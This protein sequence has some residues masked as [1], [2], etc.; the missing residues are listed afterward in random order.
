MNRPDTL[1]PLFAP[2]ANLK[3]VG[4]QR[5]K[6]LEKLC[7]G[8]KILNL[9]AHSPKT[10][11][12]RLKLK[13]IVELAEQKNLHEINTND[14]DVINTDIIENKEAQIPAIAIVLTILEH[15]PPARHRLPYRIVCFDESNEKIELLWF[16]LYSQNL[17]QQFPPTK[18]ITVCGSITYYQGKPQITHPERL[19]PESEF[20][21]LNTS[22]PQWRLTQGITRPLLIKALDEAIKAVPSLPEWLPYQL[23]EKY[24]YPNFRTAVKNLHKGTEL[25]SKRARE[26]LAY[27]ELLAHQISLNMVKRNWNKHKNINNNCLQNSE[28]KTESILNQFH[29]QLLFEPTQAQ[30]Q[31]VDDIKKDLKGEYPM[32]RLLQGDVGSGKTYVAACAMLQAISNDGQAVLMVPTDLLARQHEKSFN[33]WLEPL[34]VKVTLLS[35]SINKNSKLEAI[36]DIAEGTA[37]IIIGTHALFQQD[38][39]YKKLKLAVIDEQHKFGVYQRV[40]LTEKNKS[41]NLLV[42]SATPIPRTLMLAVWGGIDCSRLKQKPAGRKHIITKAISTKRIDEVILAL[43]KWRAQGDKIYWVCPHIKD[44]EVENITS[45]DNITSVQQR[46]KSLAEKFSHK[47]VASMHAQMSIQAREKAMQQFSE[48]EAD[49]LVATTMI[50]VGIDIPEARVIVIENAEHFGLAQLHQLRGRVGRDEKQAR[51]ILLYDSQANDIAKARIN[52]MRK[53]QDGFDIAEEDWRL[54]GSGDTLGVRQSGLPQFLFADLSEHNYLAQITAN[55]AKKIVEQ[56]AQLNINEREA[57]RLLL[58]LFQKN[59]ALMTLNAA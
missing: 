36:K 58:A 15:I 40:A 53:T 2:I 44:S 30:K 52:I 16:K 26:R 39:K 1:S 50:E 7:E 13:S 46:V 10:H 56:S 9:L 59:E 5:Q 27:D 38:I 41:M 42:M 29:K 21:N 17:K 8:D 22:E 33:K 45:V 32:L 14:S 54:R 24:S 48:G 6:A 3:G 12:E 35:A 28:Q 20:E 49:I 31:A 55:H 43:E 37:Q 34:G 23:I 18:K 4:E 51:C 19:L 47:V 11:R 25:D 57:L